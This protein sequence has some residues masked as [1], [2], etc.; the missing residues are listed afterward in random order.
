MAAALEAMGAKL[1]RAGLEFVTPASG[2]TTL[3]EHH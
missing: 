2:L 3:G 1:R